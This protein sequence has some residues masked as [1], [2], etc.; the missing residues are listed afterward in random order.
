MRLTV[1]PISEVE[2]CKNT[3]AVELFVVFYMDEGLPYLNFDLEGVSA[4]HTSKLAL[5]SS[6]SGARMFV[7]FVSYGKCLRWLV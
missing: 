6:T 4:I 2:E 3:L 5:A 7:R 1:N